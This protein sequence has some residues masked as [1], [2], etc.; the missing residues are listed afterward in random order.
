MYEWNIQ[1]QEGVTICLL[2]IDCRHT[3]W[4]ANGLLAAGQR[5]V[6]EMGQAFKIAQAGA[7]NLAAPYRPVCS[8][9]GSIGGNADGRPL[10]PMFRQ[11]AGNMGGM[12]LHANFL[13]NGGIEGI[14]RRQVFGMQ[15]IGDCL[16][17]DI[18]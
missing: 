8:V 17:V 2:K 5:Y 3:P 13:R 14:F 4:L 11:Y 12:M 18:E 15:V 10:Q 16:R 7:H 9:A 1:L 6:S